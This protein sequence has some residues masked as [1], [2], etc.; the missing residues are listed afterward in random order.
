MNHGHEYLWLTIAEEI[1]STKILELV[2]NYMYEIE[3][4]AAIPSES[5]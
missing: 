4:S 2:L 1:A 3:I 5:T